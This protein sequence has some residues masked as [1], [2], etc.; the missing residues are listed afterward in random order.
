MDYLNVGDKIFHKTDKTPATIVSIED[1]IITI[2]LENE[3]A[4]R[5]RLKLPKSHIGQWLFFSIDDMSLSYEDLSSH[6]MYAGSQNSNILEVNN[7]HKSATLLLDHLKKNY[8]FEGFFHYTDF[9]NLLSIMTDG[10]LYSRANNPVKNYFNSAN[11]EIIDHTEKDIKENVRF[12]YKGKTPTNYCIEGIRRDFCDSQMPIPVLLLFSEEIAYHQGVEFLGISGAKKAKIRTKKPDEAMT[13]F[14][15]DLIF[16]RSIYKVYSDDPRFLERK[17]NFSNHRN[18]EF[19]YPQKIS[20]SF[21]KKIV[22]RTQADMKNA[23]EIIG[24][25]S[26]YALD[27]HNYYFM[28]SQLFGTVNFLLDYEIRRA[29]NFFECTFQFFMPFTSGYKHLIIIYLKDNSHVKIDPEAPDTYVTRLPVDDFVNNTLRLRIDIHN[30]DTVEKIE[31]SINGI[32]SAVWRNSFDKV[33]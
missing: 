18:A 3:I 14:N 25:D 20:T 6:P 19:L 11:L 30:I 23:I 5:K 7:R 29:Y 10:F 28:Y 9:R 27:E 12:Y 26:R 31:Y 33:L 4:G 13:H 17:K 21:I 24:K 2:D 32:T 1:S 22:F 8:Q 16:D 15:W